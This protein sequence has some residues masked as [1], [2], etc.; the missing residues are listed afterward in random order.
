MSVLSIFVVSE[1]IG[2][3][4]YWITDILKGM[5]SEADKKNLHLE[6]FYLSTD[7]VDGDGSQ[8][9][10][11]V[12]YTK[13]W[14]EPVAAKIKQ[15]GARAIVVNASPDCG[16]SGADAFV[17]FDYKGAMKKVA[18]YL[19]YCGKTRAAFIGCSGRLSYEGKRRAF[20]AAAG[21]IGLFCQSYKY[22]DISELSSS[23]LR[24]CRNFD[25]IVCSRDAE[26]N[27][28]ITALNKR[29]IFVPEDMYVIGVGGNRMSEVST[30][31]CTTICTDFVSLGVSA[32]KLH[33]FLTQN[34]DAGGVSVAV[35]CPLIIRGSTEKKPYPAAHEQ[36]S[37]GSSGYRTDNDY[38]SYLRAEQ[39]LRNCDST[40]R[41]ILL[42]LARGK[43]MTEIAEELFISQSSVKY[44]VKKMLCG[45]DIPD[46]RELIKI[47]QIYGL[48]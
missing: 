14:L 3:D 25:A 8:L 36:P 40:D 1:Q 22:S 27:H 29:K 7:G 42:H 19:K 18:R 15:A 46:R 33:R 34:P 20:M 30:P 44:R 48:L 37:L 13:G 11:A 21:E 28:L 5:K 2:L 47:A 23:F 31:P 39:L 12:G 35:E 26:A 6:D 10:L 16:I 43:N 38:L 17:S 41:S 24:E 4:G 45:A 9:V 32:V